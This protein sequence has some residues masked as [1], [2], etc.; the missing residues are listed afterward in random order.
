MLPRH[1]WFHSAAAI[2]LII[3]CAAFAQAP[4]EARRP[5]PGDPA[6]A[7]ASGNVVVGSVTFKGNTKFSDAELLKVVALKPG[8]PM[9]K[10]LV[11]QALDRLI[12]YYRSH[13]ANLSVSPNIN[14]NGGHA[15]VQF[16]IDENGT[17]GNAGRY[18]PAGGGP[19][20]A[21]PS[22]GGTAP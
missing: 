2:F 4:T 5:G 6:T 22:G 14:P 18:E 7:G 20:G 9:S 17:K 21:P 19:P 15:S 16:V 8:E 3:S 12:G 1:I 11:D 13:G 10:D